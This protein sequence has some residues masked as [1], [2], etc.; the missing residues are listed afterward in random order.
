MMTTLFQSFQIYI[1]LTLETWAG[2]RY[3][4][5]D[6]RKRPNTT[7]QVQGTREMLHYHSFR[8]YFLSYTLSME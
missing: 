1:K 4:K 7:E 8:A 5:V 2:V 3:L 6:G